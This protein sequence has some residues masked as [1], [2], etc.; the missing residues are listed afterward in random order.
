[1]KP[2]FYFVLSG[3]LLIYVLLNYYI[4]LRG[5]QALGQLLPFF[6][7]RLYWIIF[8]IT[9]TGYIIARFTEKYL[10][11]FIGNVVTFVGSYWLAAMV[12]FLLII[13]SIDVFRM[14]DRWLN[15]LPLAWRG[16]QTVA[17]FTGTVVLVSVAIILA[18]GNWN[19]RHPQI[20][21]YDLTIEKQANSFKS[22]HVVMVSDIHLGTI[23]HNGRL[24]KMVDEI[25]ALKPDIVLLP[26]DLIDEDIGQFLHQK[27][28][29]T[30]MGLHAKYGVYAAL[31][32]HE[33]IGGH[34]DDAVK[35]LTEANVKVIRDNSVK[36]ADSF[37]VVG[38]D[39]I[40]KNASPGG[41]RASMSKLLSNLDRGLP[42]IVLDHQPQQL[43]DAVQAGVDL[44]LSGHSHKGQFF[45]F[46]LITAR[47]FEQDYGY[48]RKGTFQLIVSSGFGTWGP[49]IRVGN[50]PEIVD[51]NIS[52]K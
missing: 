33:Y 48:L 29:K 51:I 39:N 49:P 31:G 19:A 30:F 3:I 18:Y 27:M 25:N 44:Q 45:P 5:W 42:I 7:G 15:F 14:L 20:T 17:L 8:W 4:G 22:L 43:Q 24:M 23:I 32:N 35:Y 47:V 10:P 2:F 21:H 12:Y 9:A 11:E 38:R 16:N 36:I 1:M 41:A 6:N 34:A 50:T 46:N 52:F 37:Y 40:S 28:Q 13:V 26:G